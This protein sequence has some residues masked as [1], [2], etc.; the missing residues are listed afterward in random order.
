ME[1]PGIKLDWKGFLSSRGL[2]RSGT[3]A[4]LVSRP[5]LTVCGLISKIFRYSCENAFGGGNGVLRSS[6]KDREKRIHL[7]CLLFR[8][9]VSAHLLLMLRVVLPSLR[10][11][12]RLVQEKFKTAFQ[13]ERSCDHL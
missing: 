11:T 5:H 13:N 7:T 10:L 9:S 4:L 6:T 3:L 2:I 1:S 12:G 8:R